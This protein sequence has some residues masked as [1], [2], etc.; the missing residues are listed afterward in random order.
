[1]F[2]LIKKQRNLERERLIVEQ[3]VTQDLFVGINKQRSLKIWIMRIVSD[4]GFLWMS[5]IR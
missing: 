1:M 4:Q 3:I 5:G 2:C